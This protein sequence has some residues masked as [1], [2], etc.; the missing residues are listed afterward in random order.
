LIFA[1]LLILGVCLYF[2]SLSLWIFFSPSVTTFKTLMYQVSVSGSTASSTPLLHPRVKQALAY[3]DCYLED[4]LLRYRRAKSGSQVAP[5]SARAMRP[6][7]RAKATVE[8]TQFVPIDALPKPKKA[9]ELEMPELRVQDSLV[10]EN[11]ISES[12]MPLASD[13]L[14][15]LAV[16]PEDGEASE[17]AYS[18]DD[19]M[20]HSGMEMLG[21]RYASPDDYLESSEELLR[22]LA[23]EEANVEHER[24][25]LESL[26]TPFGIGSMMLMLMGS[27]MFGYLVMNP[28]TFTA[29]GSGLS[30]MVSGFRGGSPA[31]AAPVVAAAPAQGGGE[32]PKESSEFMDLSLKSLVVMGTQG[33]GTAALRLPAAIAPKTNASGAPGSIVNA[34]PGIMPTVIVPG[35]PTAAGNSAPA[36][37]AIV[38]GGTPQG[39]APSNVAA[40][41]AAK[42]KPSLY[43]PVQPQKSYQPARSTAPQPV[44]TVELPPAPSTPTSIPPVETAPVPVPEGYRVEIPYTG[45]TDLE[46]AQKSDSGA[47]FKNGEN[48]AVIQMGETY[49][50]REAAE[51]KVQQLKQQGFDGVEVQK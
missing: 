26:L 9:T 2:T 1:L 33:K 14:A 29:L 25:S 28:S 35:Q 34:Q 39:A 45:D 21:D 10:D 51:A 42:S 17:E 11:S 23:Q 43:R 27:G 44:R 41:P 15:G 40:Q 12:A 32:V 37:T 38:G 24:S 30:R 3:L 7:D 46:R 8:L 47:Y 19:L 36:G 20:N 16:I 31:P 5:S 4:E 6:D 13:V 50:S 18:L 49:S 22:S 48:G